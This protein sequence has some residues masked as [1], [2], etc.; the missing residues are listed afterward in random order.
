[1]KIYVT[2]YQPSGLIYQKICIF[3]NTAV[4]THDYAEMKKPLTVINKT[5][6]PYS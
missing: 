1:V 2:N 4:R 5:K 6:I 3:I